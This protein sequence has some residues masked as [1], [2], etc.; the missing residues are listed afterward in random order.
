V[1]TDLDY[2]KLIVPCGLADRG[3]TSL[4][5]LLGKQVPLDGAE[6]A[7]VRHFEAVFERAVTHDVEV[8][9]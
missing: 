6:D 1:N 4:Q 3:V 7:L 5:E 2:F 8:S 9:A